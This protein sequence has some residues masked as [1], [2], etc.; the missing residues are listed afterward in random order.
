MNLVYQCCAG[1]D[2]HKKSCASPKQNLP[3]NEAFHR[4]KCFG[5][6]L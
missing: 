1:L 2:V 4:L 3:S 6:T 5:A